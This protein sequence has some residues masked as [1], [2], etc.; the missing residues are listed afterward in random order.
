MSERNS[1]SLTA[2]TDTS[3][4][5]APQGASALAEQ[6]RLPRGSALLLETI[7]MLARE[8]QVSPELEDAKAKAGS[9]AEMAG[10]LV[11]KYNRQIGMAA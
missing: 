9:I 1:L 6:E 8:I 5:F 2:S 4:N 11:A 7:L 3:K 10:E